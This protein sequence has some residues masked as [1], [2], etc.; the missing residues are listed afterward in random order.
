MSDNNGATP[1]AA[2]GGLS[3][4]DV[5]KL[6]ADAL[7]Q[8]LGPIGKTLTALADGQKSLVES[9]AKLTDGLKA[10]Q[11][12]AG[13][14]A[15]KPE[16]VAKLV[17][18]QL[19]AQQVKK[20]EAD[21]AGA[22]KA[23]VRKRVVEAKLKGVPAELLG[24]LP[25]TDD[26]KALGEAA[27]GLRKQIESLPGVKLPDIGGVSKDGGATP[28]AAAEAQAKAGSGFLKMAPGIPAAAGTGTV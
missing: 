2:S 22:K 20:A 26:E 23:D 4:D 25:D 28:G 5:Q 17:A 18:D 10:V 16:D 11:E 7:S 24:S 12:S 6:V 9:N 19:A 1:P 3:K 13:K 21:A 8:A 15:A 14:G 27:D